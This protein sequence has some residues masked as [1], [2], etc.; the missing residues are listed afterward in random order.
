MTDARIPQKPVLQKSALQ[1][2]IE[3]LDTHGSDSKRLFHGRG[4][5]YSGL[6]WLTLDWHPPVLVA[7]LYQQPDQQQLQALRESLAEL[8]L[9]V[10][11]QYRYGQQLQSE[12]L[13][14]SANEPFY[15]SRNGLRFE[16]TLQQRQ[17]LGYFVDMEP[18]R[19]WLE[20]NACGRGLNLFAYTCALSCVALA[21]GASE[22]VNVDMS[23]SA[24]TTGQRNHQLNGLRGGR[25][26]KMDVFK[27][28]K[29]LAANG[30]Y[31]WIVLDPPSFQKGSFVAQKDYPRLLRHLLKV[32]SPGSKI[33]ACLND[34]NLDEA[35]LKNA[36]AEQLPQAVFVERLAEHPDFP[37][38]DRDKGL[39]LLVYRID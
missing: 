11:V 13:G 6:E 16:L 29:K 3:Q 31:D 10:F 24:L 1:Q 36:F 2:L 19:Q 14:T 12:W 15:A 21:N 22:V 30:P 33:L 34:P 7:T 9:P 35:F 28:W 25:F 26:L 20:K 4:H 38:A 37:E 8:Q 5:C 17:N 18:G 39:K 23:R 32:L 27:S